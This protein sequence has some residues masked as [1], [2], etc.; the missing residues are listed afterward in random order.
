MKLRCTFCGD[1]TTECGEFTEN[2]DGDVVHV[3]PCCTDKVD[4][5]TEGGQLGDLNTK[6]RT[7]SPARESGV[8][9][10]VA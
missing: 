4:A 9:Q 1:T 3:G 10:D 6:Y 5:L 7:T 2:E 8:A